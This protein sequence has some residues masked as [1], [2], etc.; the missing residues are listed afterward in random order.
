MWRKLPWQTR[1]T[2][3]LIAIPDSDPPPVLSQ[4][5]AG[6]AGVRTP[7]GLAADGIDTVSIRR[8]A[9]PLIQALRAAAALLIVVHH[10]SHDAASLGADGASLGNAIERAMPWQAG[11]DIFFVIS[12]FVMLHSSEALFQR[13]FWSM[14][15]FAARRIARIVPLYW[16]TTTLFLIVAAMDR[17]S[18]AASLGG[19]GYVLSS[20]AFIPKARPDGLMQPAYGLG[21]TLNYEMFFYLLFAS[22]LWMRRLRAMGVLTLALCGLVAFGTFVGFSNDS[23]RYWGNPMVLEFLLGIWIRALLPWIGPLP[24]LLRLVFTVAAVLILWADFMSGGTSRILSWG[25]PAGLL[26]MACVTAAHESVSP[27]T[28]VWVRLGDASY[29]LYLLHPFVVRAVSLVWRRFGAV[30]PLATLV[31]IFASL[32]LACLVAIVINIFVERPSTKY[33]RRWIE[34]TA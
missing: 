2:A 29:A 18:V 19:V 14:R 34:P 21:W 31:Y 1:H 5:N 30:T 13:G 8:R 9:Y 12:G 17:H 10:V 24:R 11:V 33:V 16:A 28:R 3:A 32:G 6:Y 22:C 23:L 4:A 20:Y 26:V 15:V 25:L 27:W 7:A